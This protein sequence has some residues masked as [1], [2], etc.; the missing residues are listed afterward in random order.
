MLDTKIAAKW[1]L[2]TPNCFD[3]K[4]QVVKGHF[5]LRG[6]PRGQCETSVRRCSLLLLGTARF[7]TAASCCWQYETLT[8]LASNT[9]GWV[10][11]QGSV[12]VIEDFFCVPLGRIFCFFRCHCEE[13]SDVAISKIISERWNKKRRRDY[14]SFFLLWMVISTQ[15]KYFLV[16]RNPSRLSP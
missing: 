8:G 11:R 5:T 4:K 12:T 6:S 13:R 16:F 15:P 9:N 14:P 10:A 3:G 2:T 1:P 7:V